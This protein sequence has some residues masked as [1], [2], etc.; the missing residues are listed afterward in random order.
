[1][2]FGDAFHGKRALVTGGMGFTGS[3]VAIALVYAGSQM[4]PSLMP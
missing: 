2:D 3:N 4:S 1:M